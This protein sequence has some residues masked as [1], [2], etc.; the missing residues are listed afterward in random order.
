MITNGSTRPE[1]P[2]PFPNSVQVFDG[3]LTLV[4]P[5]AVVP[6]PGFFRRIGV[7][8]GSMQ[9]PEAREERRF[10]RELITD[11]WKCLGMFESS[12]LP[13]NSNATP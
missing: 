10:R 1:H 3:C 2:T 13:R 5:R 9:A 7:W 4:P 8:R 11:R 6:G 12:L